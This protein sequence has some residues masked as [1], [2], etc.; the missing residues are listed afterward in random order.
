[1]LHNGCQVSVTAD[2]HKL[3]LRPA[4]LT[5]VSS[6][7]FGREAFDTAEAECKPKLPV[8]TSAEAE[9]RPKPHFGRHSV[10]KPNFGRSLIRCL[11]VQS[12]FTM[13]V[14][15]HQNWLSQDDLPWTLGNDDGGSLKC[16]FR[17]WRIVNAK[18]L[19]RMQ[20][21]RNSLVQCTATKDGSWIYHNNPNSKLDSMPLLQAL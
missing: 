2:W 21:S 14:S 1:M 9:S 8:T 12:L 13:T 19:Q 5:N 15:V 17:K 20:S 4:V 18:Y 6:Y 10:P 7:T 11:Q 16:L 3:W